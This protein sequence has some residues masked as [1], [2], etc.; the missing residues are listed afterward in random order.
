[1]PGCGDFQTDCKPISY[2]QDSQSGNQEG[3]TAHGNRRLRQPRRLAR[4]VATC[5]NDREVLDELLEAK[6]L[7]FGHGWGCKMSLGLRP[8]QSSNDTGKV[9]FDQLVKRPPNAI[10][11]YLTRLNNN[12]LEP[13]P[14]IPMLPSQ[15][16]TG[17]A[18]TQDHVPGARDSKKACVNVIRTKKKKEVTPKGGT[19][20]LT[21]PENADY[22]LDWHRRDDGKCIDPTVSAAASLFV[23]VASPN[24]HMQRSAAHGT[25]ALLGTQRPRSTSMIAVRRAECNLGRISITGTKVVA[26]TV[27]VGCV[28]AWRTFGRSRM[29]SSRRGWDGTVRRGQDIDDY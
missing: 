3:G 22:Q 25:T 2:I 27:S 10:T 24:D 28:G 9:V 6:R 16:G 18:Y 26:G 15:A 7:Y 29:L 23:T 11:A 13:D 5:N 1:M 4:R 12:S 14:H 19:D 8:G 20:S 21:G 17:T